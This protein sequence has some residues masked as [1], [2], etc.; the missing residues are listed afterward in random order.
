MTFGV[1]AYHTTHTATF[2]SGVPNGAQIY[3]SDG[4]SRRDGND[5]GEDGSDGDSD[6]AGPDGGG[7]RALG[8]FYDEA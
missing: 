5:A 2:I 7:G 6:G 4:L 8:D 3:F 1:R